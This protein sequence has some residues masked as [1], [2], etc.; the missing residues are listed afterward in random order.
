MAKERST[1]GIVRCEKSN[2]YT[3]AKGINERCKHNTRAYIPKSVDPTL[4]HKNKELIKM[5]DGKKYRDYCESARKQT[6]KNTG[7]KVRHD[8]VLGAE[9]IIDYTNQDLVDIDIY[10][11]A[12]DCVEWMKKRFGENNVVHATLHMD[13]I[14]KK[15]GNV[16]PH[17]HFFV[18]PV[19]EKGNLSFKSFID[20]PRA[21]EKSTSALQTEYYESVG[22]KYGMR[23]GKQLNGKIGFADHK[24][25]V[26]ATM[27]RAKIKDED[28]KPLEHE[29]DSHGNFIYEEKDGQ[30]V[31]P[32]V[33]RV[34][35]VAQALA[36][37]NLEEKLRLEANFNDRIGQLN[38]EKLELERKRKEADEKYEEEKQRMQEREKEHQINYEIQE[39]ILKKHYKELE[40]TLKKEEEIKYERVDK[41]LDTLRAYAI[42]GNMD[43]KAMTNSIKT[44]L[45]FQ[46]GLETYPDKDL[47]KKIAEG[48]NTIARYQHD[49]D[50]ENRKSL[51]KGLGV[52]ET[53]TKNTQNIGD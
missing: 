29:L 10:A 6:E 7:K 43:F 16:H 23:R 26:E 50:K 12:N 32:Y 33:E 49:I 24:K 53:K 44:F 34:K 4:S 36:Y 37:Q 8:A 21:G 15:T 11:W 17:I 1:T 28:F 14:D 2:S 31:C 41:F 5:E 18:V 22:K 35:D 13:E 42:G 51:E 25:Y 39:E 19:N 30:K 47:A 27:G 3:G 48:Y 40:E 45:Q 46:R 20:G 52:N 38:R 9:V